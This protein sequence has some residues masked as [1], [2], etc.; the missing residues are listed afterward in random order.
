MD[1][2]KTEGKDLHKDHRFRM[3]DK[4]LKNG[5]DGFPDHEKLEFLLFFAIP[6]VNTNPIAHLLLKKFG[7]FAGVLD[8]PE[9]ELLKVDGIGENSVMFLKLLPQV[10]SYYI[11]SSRDKEKRFDKFKDICDFLVSKYIGVTD[12]QIYL[13]CL[14][15]KNNILYDGV[16]QTGSVNN[17]EIDTRRIVEIALSNKTSNVIIAHNHPTGVCKPSFNDIRST[18]R[19]ESILKELSI[20]LIAHVLVA[21]GK[22][23]IVESEI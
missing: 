11:N 20:N 13:I 8:A 14:D 4:Y 7:T 15:D 6:R 16:V 10:A 5:F 23:C 21:E 17:V 9:S 3:R 12:E 19:L 2:K 22:Y 1:K 18:A